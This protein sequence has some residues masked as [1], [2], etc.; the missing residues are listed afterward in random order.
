MQNIKNII[1]DL[2]NVILNI[3]YDAPVQAFKKLGIQNFETFFSK[4]A[5]TSLADDIETGKISDDDFIEI[6][7]KQCK[8]G[9]ST[10]QVIDAWNAIILNF[11]LKRLQLLQQLQ[12]HY[13]MYLLSNTNSIHE[14]CYNKLLF[15]SVGYNTMAVFFDKIYLSHRVG[16]RKPDTKAWQ[17]ILD[18]NNLK[19]EETL[20]LDDSPQHIAAAKTL[21]IQCIHITPD[22]NM[23]DVFKQKT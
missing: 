20:F 14:E 9:T 19:P 5:Q 17:L 13:N 10:L 1:F 12:L 18:E 8:P 23:E 4:A 15:T 6:L 11:P 2:G 16:L 21:G 22:N 3:D 7:Q